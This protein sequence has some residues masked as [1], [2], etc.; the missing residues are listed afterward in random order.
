MAI[1]NGCLADATDVMNA[2]KNTFKL[3]AITTNQQA[4][5]NW[6][7]Q[8]YS[9]EQAN[10]NTY[11]LIFGLSKMS[12]QRGTVSMLC[13]QGYCFTNFSSNFPATG[14]VNITEGYNCT[15]GVY[16]LDRCGLCARPT[17]DNNM[18]YWGY[19]CVCTA[20]TATLWAARFGGQR[21]GFDM[22]CSA[23]APDGTITS[24]CYPGPP[25]CCYQET[26]RW[27][28]C[29]RLC[30]EGCALRCAS[31]CNRGWNFCMGFGS[32][33]FYNCTCSSTACTT[34]SIPPTLYELKR[35]PN[36]LNCY[37]FYKDGVFQCCIPGYGT[38]IAGVCST[39]WACIGADSCS[40]TACSYFN[41]K[42]IEICYVNQENITN[43][44]CLPEA[45]NYLVFT[46][47]QSTCC[48]GCIE[49][50]KCTY[51][52]TDVIMADLLCCDTTCICT[53]T[54]NQ[55]VKIDSPQTCYRLRLYNNTICCNSSSNPISNVNSA[56]LGGFA[57]QGICYNG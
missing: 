35:I 13:E 53:L 9:T 16:T 49:C 2:Y 42:C 28:D 10:C 11:C 41:I 22:T 21:S 20:G 32:N 26:R 34:L 7:N 23:C 5:E 4:I 14:C 39:W 1:C 30:W 44:F 31:A 45:Y 33:T 27:A 47:T 29:Y 55:I 52:G 46:K 8:N 15:Y 24:G 18:N 25:C 40:G 56:W 37:C 43:T 51:T 38:N 54:P 48:Y 6:T 19:W 12:N 57:L 36:T 3:F 17:A 50:N